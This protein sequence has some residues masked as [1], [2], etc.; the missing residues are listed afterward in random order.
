MC[1]KA[2][3]KQVRAGRHAHIEHPERSRA[4]KTKAFSTLPGYA[5]LFDQC[6]YGATIIN[7]DGFQEPIKKSPRIQTTKMSMYKLINRRCQGDHTHCPLE[8][9]M[10]GGGQ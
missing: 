9:S 4:W 8:G 6:E 1:H 5:A 10:P 3:W 2:Y 7:N